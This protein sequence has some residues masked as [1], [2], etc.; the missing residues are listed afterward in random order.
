MKLGEKIG[1]IFAQHTNFQVLGVRRNPSEQ[2]N[3]PILAKDIFADD[4]ELK[5]FPNPV[6][7]D[8]IIRFSLDKKSALQL[9][10]VNQSGQLI[11]T[12]MQG[13]QM[14]G[15][16]TISFSGISIPAGIYWLNLKGENLQKTIPIQIG[17]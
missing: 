14:K 17:N 16:H 7:D 5:V 8:S 4:F 2:G 13:E 11:K 10:I 15:E 12:L 6:T 3:F 1:D 9:S